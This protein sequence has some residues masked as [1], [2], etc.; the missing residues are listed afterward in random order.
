MSATRAN[1]PAQAPILL[2][3]RGRVGTA[4]H[5]A[6]A[7]GGL[8]LTLAGRDDLAE[9]AGDASNVLLCVPDAEIATASAVVAD[10]APDLRFLGHTS[11]AT[12][13]DELG[14]ASRT[15]AAT[16]SLHP[17]QTIPDGTAELV[18]S[19]AAI[20]GSG[21]EALAL[22]R[23]LADALGMDPFEVPEESR[24]AYHAAACIASNFLVA[25]ESSAA[26][27][28]AAAGI[29]TPDEARELLAPLVLRSAANWAERGPEGLTGPIARG[30]EETVERHLAAI[31]GVAPELLALYHALAERTRALAAAREGVGA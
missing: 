10:A 26:E 14:A 15:G 24:A 25:L 11:G 5:R 29:A 8:R 17:L 12:G 2:V 4:I 7:T 31:D 27:L 30:D 1:T 3:G 18:G 9:L 6:G 13:L 16:F 23:R 19:P 22:A 20:A 21:P 28:L